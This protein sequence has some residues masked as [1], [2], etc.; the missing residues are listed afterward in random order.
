MPT[1]FGVN[2]TAKIA[3]LVNS[4]EPELLG[5]KVRWIYESYTLLGT[6]TTADVIQLGGINLPA[7]SRIVNWSIDHGAL[8][9]GLTLAF[10]TLASGA[11]FMAAA[12]CAT[13][14]KKSYVVNGV[15]L[16]LG[17]EITAGNGQIPTLTIAGGT[18]AAVAIIV[19]I[20]FVAKG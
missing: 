20:S 10:G 15:A 8:G 9:A 11:V 13:A 19:G 3:G 4:I 17:Y 6:E 1:F 18:A 2:R 7:E 12:D 16:S 5:G 14:G